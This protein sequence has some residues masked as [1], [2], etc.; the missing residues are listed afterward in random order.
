MKQG[1]YRVKQFRR[2]LTDRPDQE[3]L[4]RVE[5]VLAPL[6][7]DLF[8]RMLPFEQAHAIRVMKG[9]TA[10]GYDHPDVLTAALLHDVGKLNVPLRPLERALAVL[11]RWLLPGEYD[12]SGQGEAK[13]FQKGIVVAARHAEWGAE[14]AAEHGA[15]QRAIFLIRF[16]DADL[17]QFDGQDRLVLSVLQAVD[18]AN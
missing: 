15:S 8:S 1:L 17:A 18:A 3:D 5:S 6:L 14:L 7:F 4:E 2:A 12:H 9:M 10:R 16:H 11:V 13:G